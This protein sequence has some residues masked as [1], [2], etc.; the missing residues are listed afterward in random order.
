MVK[1]IFFPAGEQYDIEVRKYEKLIDYQG[2]VDGLIE[3]SDI[4]RPDAT[5]FSNE[6]GLLRRLDINRRA[7]LVLWLHN[8]RNRGHTALRG[9]VVIIGRPDADGATQDVPD[10]LIELLFNTGPTSTR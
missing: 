2:D 10:E 9:D 5:I 4:A 6:E 1:G 8:S 7:S 3:A